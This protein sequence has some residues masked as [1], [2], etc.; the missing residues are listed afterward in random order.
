MTELQ[1]C[2]CC[3]GDA[4]YS[5]YTKP[6]VDGEGEKYSAFVTCSVC[7]LRTKS[8]IRDVSYSAESEAAT[9]W[10]A[11]VNASTDPSNP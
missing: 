11:R 9:V 7:G 10:N 1:K 3:G 4:I 8:F 2:P 6:V 5:Y